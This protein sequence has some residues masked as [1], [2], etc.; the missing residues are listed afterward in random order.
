MVLVRVEH[1]R[2]DAL[3][4]SSVRPFSSVVGLML[5]KWWRLDV[6]FGL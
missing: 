2:D 3:G 4:L 1:D 5:D 6:L